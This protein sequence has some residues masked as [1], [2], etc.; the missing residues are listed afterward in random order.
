MS[1][2]GCSVPIYAREYAPGRGTTTLSFVRTL[3]LSPTLGKLFLY[4]LRRVVQETLAWGLRTGE[5][6]AP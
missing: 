5:Y 6:A 1:Y 2:R 3:G 4:G